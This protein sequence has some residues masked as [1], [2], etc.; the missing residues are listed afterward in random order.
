MPCLSAKFVRLRSLDH[1]LRRRAFC[2]DVWDWPMR[3]EV[4]TSKEEERVLGGV[5]LKDTF[6]LVYNEKEIDIK[7]YKSPSSCVFIEK[8]YC[9]AHEIPR[10]WWVSWRNE[11]PQGRPH[12]P[13]CYFG[14]AKWGV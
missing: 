10:Q 2:V 3:R 1:L 13:E 12:G 14:P 6:K 5:S 4:V 7:D 11:K 9:I 8:K